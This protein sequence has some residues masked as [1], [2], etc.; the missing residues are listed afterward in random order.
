[1]KVRAFNIFFGGYFA[2]VAGFRSFLVLNL[3]KPEPKFNIEFRMMN[4][5]VVTIQHSTFVIRY[6]S[7]FG[8]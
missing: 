6:S 3:D 5:E 4:Y 8:F 1:M 7:F 2:A